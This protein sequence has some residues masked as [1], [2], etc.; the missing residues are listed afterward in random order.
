MS[1]AAGLPYAVLVTIM[2]VSLWRTLKEEDVVNPRKKRTFNVSLFDIFRLPSWNN[3]ARFL[4]AVIAPWLPAGRAAGKL[5]HK[6]PWSYML[7]MAVLFYGWGILEV[8]EVVAN[9]LAY[10]RWVVMCG[11]LTYLM[12]LGN[13][14]REECAIPG[15][16]IADGLAAI[17][18]PFTVDQMDKHMLIAEQQKKR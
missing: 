1:V 11:F 15:S 18:Y 10:L 13:A 8:T 5:Y 12:G 9:G 7:I 2:C 16:V 14:I 4:T 3:V 17:L 6:K